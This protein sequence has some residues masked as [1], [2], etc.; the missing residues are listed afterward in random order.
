MQGKPSTNIGYLSYTRNNVPA[1]QCEQR[2][3]TG[4]SILVSALGGD[5]EAETLSWLMGVL[6]HAHARGQRG[7][8]GYVEAVVEDVG[9]KYDA[10]KTLE[11]FSAMLRDE[12]D[13]DAV[14][15]DLI[16]GGEGDYAA[17]P[18]LAVVCAP[19]QRRRVKALA[20]RVRKSIR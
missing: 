8:G 18:R 3:V 20:N 10:S 19:T 13:L 17:S 2:Y 9:E 6:R 5:T 11:R 1:L 12:T 14:S 16:G 15:D 7:L 4:G